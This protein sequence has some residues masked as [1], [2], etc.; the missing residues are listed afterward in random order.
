MKFSTTLLGFVILPLTLLLHEVSGQEAVVFNLKGFILDVWLALCLRL[1][2]TWGC[3]LN[4]LP[5]LLGG[6]NRTCISKNNARTM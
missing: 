3:F 6:K 4:A 1:N 5:P 2:D